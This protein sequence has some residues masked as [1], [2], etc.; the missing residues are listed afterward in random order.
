VSVIP[1]VS[2]T[3]GQPEITDSEPE[4][5]P[6]LPVVLNISCVLCGYLH[7]DVPS[8]FVCPCVIA[9]P[10]PEE[11]RTLPDAA[12]RTDEPEALATV[13]APCVLLK[14]QRGRKYHV[15]PTVPGPLGGD[16]RLP[17]KCGQAP[18]RLSGTKTTAKRGDICARCWP[19]TTWKH[20]GRGNFSPRETEL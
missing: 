20:H 13:L 15:H 17:A 5:P 2:K 11:L 10:L 7:L 3:N 4:P 8:T 1:E 19:R 9:Q 6:T 16:D 18:A 12:G 14:T